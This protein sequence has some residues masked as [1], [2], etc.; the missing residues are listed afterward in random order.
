M[1][2]MTNETLNRISDAELIFHVTRR[3][4]DAGVA[5]V[6][7]AFA[8]ALWE[9]RSRRL[10]L[11][12][13]CLGHYSL[14]Y[15][16][17]GANVVFAS[18]PAMLFLLPGVPRRLDEIELA[19]FIVYNLEEPRRT[20]YRAIDRVP[21]R[22]MVTFDE[23]GV[24]SRLYWT[25]DPDAAHGCK[26]E[27]DYVD[28]ARELLDLAVGLAAGGLPRLAIATSGGLDSSAVVATAARLNLAKS[29]CCYTAV[30]PNDFDAPPSAGRY[31]DERS[32]VQALARKYPEIEVQYL[33]PTINADETDWRE[34]FVRTGMPLLGPAP[35]IDDIVRKIASYGHRVYLTGQFGNHGLS[36]EGMFSLVELLRQA[37]LRDFGRELLAVAQEEQLGIPRALFNQV[38]MLAAPSALRRIAQRIRRRDPYD[39]ARLGALNPEFAAQSELHTMW[40]ER[41]FDPWTLIK[42]VD[43]S[44]HRAARLF[45]YNQFGR[46]GRALSVELTGMQMRDP[47][48]ERRLAEFMVSVPEPMFRKN[49]I[50]SSFAR[51]VL[52]DRLPQE[53][54]GERRSGAQQVSWFRTLKA[55]Q[56]EFARTLENLEASP[57]VCRLIDLQRL[58]RLLAELPEDE[59]SAQ[60]RKNDYTIIL[61]RAIYVG[62]FIR[63][64]EGGNA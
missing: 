14:F 50:R 8:F 18:T 48:K 49:G 62:T 58:R 25:P 30:P 53:I 44:K 19:N 61:N 1:V 38:F 4:G 56:G 51:R 40:Q 43:G 3:W 5:R 41:D 64:V 2:G 10:T 17:K 46:D 47:F 35:F 20:F 15:H 6:L 27:Q 7:G 45:D 9:G 21:S 52:A 16:R 26:S 29:I 37:R 57:L 59:R 23:K 11:G 13:D 39:V 34:R 22:T 60:S 55:R 36:W 63:W 42:G 12:R 31:I 32:K 33:C 28:R 24:H 54:V